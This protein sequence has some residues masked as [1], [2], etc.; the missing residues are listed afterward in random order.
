M[1]EERAGQAGKA[2][3]RPLIGVALSL[4]ALAAL[5]GSLAYWS[6]PGPLG[7]GAPLAPEPFRVPE[8][9]YVSA[10]TSEALL[11]KLRERGGEQWPPAERVAPVTAAAFPP[12]LPELEV[13]ARKELFFRVLT[14]IVLAENAR[15]REA[16]RFIQEAAGRRDALSEAE[17]ERLAQLAELY[18]VDLD[19]EA[20]PE[21]L[22][23]R[24]DEIPPAMALAQAA[25]ESGWGTSRFTRE[26]N[27]LFGEWTW[28]QEGLIP[29]QRSAGK[30]HRVRLFSSLQRSVRSYLYL[31]NV[32]GAYESLRSRRAQMREAGEPLEGLALAKGLTAYSERGQAYVEEI[33]S[34]IRYNELQ[35]MNGLRLADTERVAAEPVEP[36][37]G[38]EAEASEE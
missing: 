6:I 32:G 24:V 4:G 1:S 23:R 21:R 31:L 18:R 38:P 35:R 27:N 13:S 26:A 25:N 11:A 10:D 17:Q 36:S 15:V 16:R 37:E 9:T 34:M 19:S 8:L 29:K 33:R 30:T 12:D 7:E 5:G 2:R 3:W 20:A 28:T 14:P 22:L